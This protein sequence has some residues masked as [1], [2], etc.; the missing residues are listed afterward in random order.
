MLDLKHN[1]ERLHPV[2]AAKK[3]KSGE[4][5]R[6]TLDKHN[7]KEGRK[8]HEL[9]DNVAVRLARKVVKEKDKEKYLQ[10]WKDCST[11]AFEV[12]LLEDAIAARRSTG[13][14]GS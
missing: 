1:L 6:S 14:G 8:S 3:N 4:E 12:K 7:C 10:R 13:G 11:E 9:W 2:D 5:V